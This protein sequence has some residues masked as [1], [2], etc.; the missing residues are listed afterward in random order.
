MAEQI[1]YGDRLFL[2]GEKVILDNG[3][4]TYYVE[5][6][7]D[8]EDNLLNG[9]NYSV[10]DQIVVAGSNL[11]GKDVINN[12]TITVVDTNGPDGGIKSLTFSGLPA[13]K[14]SQLPLRITPDGEYLGDTKLGN[15]KEYTWTDSIN[16]ATFIIKKLKNVTPSFEARNGELVL[17]FNADDVQAKNH[18]V[19][20]KGDLT[21]EGTTTTVNSEKITFEDPVIEIGAAFDEQ[22]KPTNIVHDEVGFKFY[23]NSSDDVALKFLTSGAG[24]DDWPAEFNFED[25]PSWTFDYSPGMAPETDRIILSNLASTNLYSQN[26]Q[27]T[28]GTI[29]GTAIGSSVSSTGVFSTLT[30]DLVD[31]NGGTIDGT[32]IGL[33]VPADAKFLDTTVLGQITAAG[34]L[35]H[36]IGDFTF[37]QNVMSVV[38]T[39]MEIRSPGGISFYPD[40]DNS[41]PAP[42]GG[43]KIVWLR[44]GA[45][46]VFEGT[47]PDDFEVKLQA[48]DITEDRD[49]ILPDESGTLAL[50][51]W[52]TREIDK[53]KNRISDTPPENPLNGNL[54]WNSNTGR[55][56]IYY[57]D[58]DSSQWVDAVPAT[59]TVTL[60]GQGGSTG[61]VDLSN[62]YTKAEVDNSIANIELIPGPQGI[63]GEPGIDGLPGATGATG[64]KGDKG[65][66]GD[67]GPQGIQG[68]QGPQGDTGPTG[69]QGP[70]GTDA[71]ID[72]NI[73]DDSELFNVGLGGE[74]FSPWLNYLNNW[75]LFSTTGNHNVAVGWSAMRSA[76]SADGN[77]AVGSGALRDI[78]SGGANSAL[79]R[80]ALLNLETG[81][82]NTAVGDGALSN[83]DADATGNTAIGFAAGQ[84]NYNN[85][86]HRN[87]FIGDRAAFRVNGCNNVIIGNRANMAFG[88]GTGES[89]INNKLIIASNTDSLD[90]SQPESNSA[91]VLI[92]GDFSTGHVTFNDAYTFPSTDGTENQVL[93]TDGLGNL[94][95]SDHVIN[96]TSYVSPVLEVD[97]NALGVY[98]EPTV[99][100]LQTYS[101]VYITGNTSDLR[102]IEIPNGTVSGQRFFWFNDGSQVV[103][104][105]N[106]NTNS[107]HAE[108]EYVWTGSVWKKL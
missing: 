13:F 11:D 19:V 49:I 59:G 37:N 43:E 38:T 7:K 60:S 52:T 62:Y 45:K 5:I 46:L 29:D 57:E 48:T 1:K 34:N 9:S 106:G 2:A 20:I 76:T 53:I 92:S 15:T 75:H 44:D 21:V 10:G 70:A 25:Y 69:P 8:E 18:H 71:S 54:W 89:N 100:D 107:G 39:D 17:G 24:W 68:P 85:P 3:K 64:P 97:V 95:W 74:T 16:N 55:L 22:G 98:D 23:L 81:H 27:I 88:E 58:V 30:S 56:K 33:D 99:M 36:Q 61:T 32:F 4:Y 80:G 14:S 50:Q 101:G 6:S 26:V 67:Q 51:E 83:Y 12:L 47:V 66:T 87:V 108:G 104:T 105:I 72:F 78:I 102:G 94:S 63:Q 90:S 103:L 28:G 35:Q 93:T 65:D 77:T 42:Q 31:L 96:A 91:N 86:G 82:C 79:G 84:G 40:E 73:T 41:N